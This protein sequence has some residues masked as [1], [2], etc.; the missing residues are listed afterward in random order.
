MAIHIGSSKNTVSCPELLCLLPLPSVTSTAGL[1]SPGE[2][3]PLQFLPS[4][5]KNCWLAL[6]G[7]AQWSES[8]PVH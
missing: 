4:P 3:S 6:A 7:V 8:L 1:H 5:Y 2:V